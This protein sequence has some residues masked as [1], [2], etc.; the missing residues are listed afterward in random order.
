VLV[1]GSQHDLQQHL[2]LAAGRVMVGRPEAR[3][4]VGAR[5]AA[6]SV[7]RIKALSRPASAATTASQP[8]PRGGPSQA[9]MVRQVMTVPYSGHFCS[10]GTLGLMDILMGGQA[11]ATEVAS[12]SSSASSQRSGG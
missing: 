6:T 5:P 4:G 3:G 1:A 11:A 9:L 8:T 12:G 2:G 10:D 7:Q